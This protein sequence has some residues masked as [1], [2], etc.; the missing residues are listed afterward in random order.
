MKQISEVIFFLVA[1]AFG[2]VHGECDVCNT[3]NPVACHSETVYSLCINDQPT[4]NFVTC[5]A[6]YI[7]TSD[8][9]VCYPSN[10]S[11]ASCTNSTIDESSQCGICASRNNLY[12]CLNET[13][14]AFCFTDGVPHYES[15]SYCPAGT[16][17]DLNAESGFCTVST[18]AAVL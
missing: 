13:T 4:M 1:L 12:A 7:C 10:S 16:V 8:V 18:K 2:G 5:P 15:L 6:D 3:N 9:Y 11:V 17:C 14:I